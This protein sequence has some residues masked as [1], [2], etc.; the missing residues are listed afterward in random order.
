MYTAYGA[1]ELKARYQRN[2][3]WSMAVVVCC[4]GSIGIAIMLTSHSPTPRTVA[5]ISYR[6]LSTGQTP[7]IPPRYGSPLGGGSNDRTGF[8]GFGRPIRV[9]PDR[10][11]AVLATKPRARIP[12][13]ELAEIDDGPG[14]DTLPFGLLVGVSSSTLSSGDYLATL[15]TSPPGQYMVKEAGVIHKVDPEFPRDALRW[16]KHG[17]LTIRVCVGADGTLKPFEIEVVKRH[18]KVVQQ[19]MYVV[20]QEQPKGF[21]FAEN[22]LKVL[23]QWVFRP[24][25]ESGAPVDA[26]LDIKY[27]FIP[28][29]PTHSYVDQR[30]R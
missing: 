23:P 9:V 24:R 27:T 2:M 11:E 4:F 8:L 19:V 28:S 12:L 1:Y 22:L 16:R 5:G 29:E 26:L 14:L 15:D 13:P 3:L 6:M 18:K 30:R 10:P 17:Q 25:I 21:F 7:G 20:T